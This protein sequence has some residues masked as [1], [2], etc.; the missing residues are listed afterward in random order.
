MLTAAELGRIAAVEKAGADYLSPL[1]NKVLKPLVSPGTVALEK[2]LGN[3]VG[4]ATTAEIKN[5]IP[6]PMTFQSPR[7]MHEDG[8]ELGHVPIGLSNLP[9]SIPVTG[10][11]DDIARRAATTSLVGRHE[12]K[13]QGTFQHDGHDIEWLM[14]P[15]Q[16]VLKSKGS[17]RQS[18]NTVTWLKA[19]NLDPADVLKK[20]KEAPI[21]VMTGP[22]KTV[23]PDTNFLNQFLPQI[24]KYMQ[25]Y[26]SILQKQ[27]RNFNH[28]SPEDL[29]AARNQ[30]WLRRM[31]LGGTG[32]AGATGAAGYALS[33]K[34]TPQAP[35][36]S[37]D[38][39]RAEQGIFD[40][41]PP[42]DLSMA[43]SFND[44][45]IYYKHPKK[46]IG[47]FYGKD[48][49]NEPRFS[50]GPKGLRKLDE[51][52]ANMQR[53]KN[54]LSFYG[55]AQNKKPQDAKAPNQFSMTQ[56]DWADIG[57]SEF[58]LKRK[59]DADS[60]AERNARNDENERQE[61][62]RR[63]KMYDAQSP[64]AYLK[65]P[66]V[67]GGL[68]IGALG[69]GGYAAYKMYQNSKKKKKKPEEPTPK[70]SEKSDT[71][72]KAAY[73]GSDAGHEY[74]RWL[75][76]GPAYDDRPLDQ[77]R[78]RIIDMTRTLADAAK[79]RGGNVKFY[80]ERYGDP[81]SM[82][83]ADEAVKRLMAAKEID[84]TNESSMPNYYSMEHPRKPRSGLAEL[85]RLKTPAY[86]ERDEAFPAGT[87]PL[88]VINKKYFNG[89]ATEK[90]SGELGMTTAFELGCL[91]AMEKAGVDYL[92]PLLKVLKPA[93][94]PAAVTAG[95]AGSLYGVNRYAQKGPLDQQESKG[96]KEPLKQI[97]SSTDEDGNKIDEFRNYGAL[98]GIDTFYP[99]G[100]RKTTH[101][102]P[103]HKWE[104]SRVSPNG[105]MYIKE[106]NNPVADMF[107]LAANDD[108]TLAQ[109]RDG[110]EVGRLHTRAYPSNLREADESSAAMQRQR[111]AAK[112]EQQKVQ[113][114]PK[115]QPKAP[116]QPK[117]QP[118]APEQPKT[119]SK[120]LLSHLK[121]PY[122]LGGL[123][124]GALGLGG[125]AA[126]KM[127]QNSKKKKKKS[128]EPTEKT[129]ANL[130]LSSVPSGAGPQ[131]MYNALNMFNQARTLVNPDET[132]KRHKLP[133][134]DFDSV[135]KDLSRVK[136]DSYDFD[137]LRRNPKQE[138]IYK[139]LAG[140]AL[141]GLGG[142]F[143]GGGIGSGLGGAALGGL[144]GAAYGYTDA[145]SAN[146][147]L[148]ATA[149]VLREYGL[150]K[151][152]HLQAALPLLK[153]IH[154]R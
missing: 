5:S 15:V 122:V 20:L 142:Y 28:I 97:I 81:S 32:A 80:G 129:S 68:G 26:P 73:G 45:G 139:G 74:D 33:G 24:E 63:Q 37:T 135:L 109:H 118:K 41:E 65:N 147:R 29:S 36:P 27:P 149:K 39:P 127:Y 10:T 94:K 85:L 66:Y 58:N 31:L 47:Y 119:N 67:L 130:G 30:N 131:N 138:A 64:M 86:M 120:S 128:E 105:A 125:Y 77:S 140:V 114:Q 48:R 101:T 4:K 141:G 79:A 75:D 44:G 3:T 11:P 70:K 91:S 38:L 55:A 92:T 89:P 87:H 126:Y 6:Y 145:G 16:Q 121:N 78:Q 93:A 52:S 50:P 56:G 35:T 2:K 134:E 100:G 14:D 69:L 43:R 25:E 150:L 72:E 112:A 84:D 104:E 146:K 143:G 136:G 40:E 103:S 12:G 49:P 154:G 60:R 53:Q 111:D 110:T 108:G 46:D 148:L 21:P 76:S 22:E 1:W 151:P 83:S 51:S 18:H 61:N 34:D 95:L 115:E 133:R 116:E 90:T 137:A 42:W 124:I 88:E 132:L 57:D 123:G 19:L 98:S 113:E 82:Y 153:Q 59:R 71:N 62:L 99:D 107:Y 8:S 54:T 117:E 102:D 7:V 144:G 106:R 9:K 17:G 96:L 13:T 23:R 152:D